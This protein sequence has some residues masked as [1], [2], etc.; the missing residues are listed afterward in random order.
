[1]A[2][3]MASVRVAKQLW[4]TRT[5]G[6]SSRCRRLTVAD[7]TLD[8]SHR[9]LWLLAFIFYFFPLPTTTNTRVT[10]L[11]VSVYFF[12]VHHPD[13]GTLFCFVYQ[14]AAALFAGVDCL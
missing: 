1:M 8:R 4:P 10:V 3:T 11:S 5:V 12:E 9:L 7:S 13:V 14:T 6:R 2:D